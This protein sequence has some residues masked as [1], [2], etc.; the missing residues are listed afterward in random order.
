MV[1]IYGSRGGL[2]NDGR[3]PTDYPSPLS[4]ISLPFPRS[5]PSFFFLSSEIRKDNGISRPQKPIFPWSERLVRG[6]TIDP[7]KEISS[8]HGGCTL[9]ISL[10]LRFSLPQPLFPRPPHPSSPSFLAV[11]FTA[12]NNSF[13]DVISLRLC[14]FPDTPVL[15]SI[16]GDSYRSSSPCMLA[17]FLPG[18]PSFSF[19]VS[20]R[21]F[22]A[23]V[24]DSLFP[25][26]ARRQKDGLRRG[27]RPIFS[28]AARN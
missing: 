14:S 17:T 10:F 15:Y 1:L 21:I 16:P 4:S 18:M 23:I 5:P 8:S 7:E 25:S 24:R 22:P 2:G 13:C 19:P 9:F 28:C 6:L 26:L 12:A 20:L 27:I 3:R 11:L